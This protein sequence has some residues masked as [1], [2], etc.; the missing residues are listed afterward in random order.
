MIITRTPF[1][2][3]FFGGGTDYL[4]W[5]RQHGGTVLSTTIDKYCYITCRKLPPFFDHRH[6][7]VYSRIENVREIDEIQHPAARAI[8]SEF[9]DESG[10]EIHHDGDLPA[11]AGLGSSSAFT[12]GLLH[13]IHALRGSMASKD[14]L[15]EQAI[16]IEQTV[17][18]ENVG[19]QDQVAVAFGGLNRIEF[20]THGGF[21][22]QPVICSSGRIANLESRLLLFFT[23]VSRIASHIAAEQIQSLHRH[24]AALKRMRAQVDEAIAILT[25]P[26]DDIDD[27]GRLLH[28]GWMLK[29]SLSSRISTPDIDAVYERAVAAGALGGKLLGAGGGGFILFFVQPGRRAAVIEALADLVHVPIRLERDGSQIIFYR[30]QET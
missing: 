30:P 12:V 23:G 21:G 7:L 8:L 17:L 6:R 29:K 11:R 19:A 10:M 14:A 20:P 9:G 18:A 22:V 26:G 27:F 13:A 25:S 28:E 15:A 16:H 24:E 3:S 4:D 2:V 1:R 5:V